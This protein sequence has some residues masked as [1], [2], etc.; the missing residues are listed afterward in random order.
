MSLI[1][2]IGKIARKNSYYDGARESYE[3]RDYLNEL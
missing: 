3:K 1:N 2:K